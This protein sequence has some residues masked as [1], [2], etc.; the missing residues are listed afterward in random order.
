MRGVEFKGN[1]RPDE[2]GFMPKRALIDH[3]PWLLSG[4]LL[5]IAFW[6]L[7]DG[8]IG[9]VFLMALKGGSV[10]ALAAYAWARCP[11]LDARLVAAVMAI[12][13]AGDIGMELD[14]VVGGGLF[15][16]SHLVAIALYVRNRRVV[17]SAT[18]N[19][20][21][22]SILIGVPIAAWLLA[23]DPLAVIYAITLATMAATAWRS[24]FSRYRVGVGTLLFVAS[25]LLIFARLGERLDG[26]TT[27]WLVWPLYYSGQLLIATGAIRTLRSD[28]KS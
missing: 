4:I 26:A 11:G 8:R 3:R 24:R 17:L 16:V 9:G 7:S 5:A 28:Q 22:V 2:R 19:A 12:G 18:Q 13:A 10:A 1:Q 27:S 21:A 14:T 23:R 6:M 20:A 15:L 25:D